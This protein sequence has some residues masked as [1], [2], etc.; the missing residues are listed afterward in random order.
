MILAN[1]PEGI[2]YEWEKPLAP[3]RGMPRCTLQDFPTGEGE[4]TADALLGGVRS[5]ATDKGIPN[6]R[7][8][9]EKCLLLLGVL[10][11][12]GNAMAKASCFSLRFSNLS[13]ILHCGDRSPNY[14][15]A[16][17]QVYFGSNSVS[18]HPS[19]VEG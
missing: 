16:Q 12:H 17:P 18:G 3:G 4:V 13:L 7:S 8:L 15:I 11:C 2:V 10:Q 6:P 19:L 1:S 14:L 9:P 5:S